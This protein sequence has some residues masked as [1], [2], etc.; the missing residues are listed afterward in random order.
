MNLYAPHHKHFVVCGA[1]GT[2]L[3]YNPHHPWVHVHAGPLFMSVTPCLVVHLLQIIS[4]P[5]SCASPCFSFMDTII[6]F[7]FFFFIVAIHRRYNFV[8]PFPSFGFPRHTHSAVRGFV[9]SHVQVWPQRFTDSSTHNRIFPFN[10]TAGR[11][12][13][14][15]S[16]F[17][18]ISRTV[19]D[20][21][22]ATRMLVHLYVERMAETVSGG[23]L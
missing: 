20:V 7:F 11:V 22:V 17:D 21:Q 9:L 23:A 6:F 4:A 2:L 10:L 12:I 14:R 18:Y 8:T 13:R 3:Q 1:I 5:S 15:P 16:L 19:S